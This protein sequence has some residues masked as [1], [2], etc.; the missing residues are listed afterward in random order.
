MWGVVYD[1][2]KVVRSGVI[3]VTISYLKSVGPNMSFH[4]VVGETARG[5]VCCTNTPSGRGGECRVGFSRQLLRKAQAAAHETPRKVVAAVF[6]V[7][8]I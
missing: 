6:L 4:N 8:Q 2:Q 7:R 5:S 3:C 1:G